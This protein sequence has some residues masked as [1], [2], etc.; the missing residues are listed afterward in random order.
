MTLRSR[1]YFERH[2]RRI[3]S[4]KGD[5]GVALWESEE[6]HGRSKVDDEPVGDLQTAQ[7]EKREDC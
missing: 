5:L 1:D 6:G 7:E 2:P 3:A 4:C